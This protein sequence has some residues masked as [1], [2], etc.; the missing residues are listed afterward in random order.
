MGNMEEGPRLMKRVIELDPLSNFYLAEMA[1]MYYFFGE[2][3]KT[4]EYALKSLELVPDFPFSLYVLGEGYAGKGMYD[5]AI[6]VQKKS[7]EIAPF[8]EFGLA[9]TYALAGYTE[10]ALKIAKKLEKRNEIWDTW[11]LAVI[12]SALGNADK[13][14]YWLGKAEELGHPYILW[15][16]T[17]T[18]FLD[19]KDDPRYRNLVKKL[20]LPQ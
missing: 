6:E 16:K 8:H 5:K 11:C 17:Q 2:Y 14:F 4:I 15:T 18:Y 20:D 9:H 1:L 10:E 3:D 7:V 12:Y 13:M 19:Y